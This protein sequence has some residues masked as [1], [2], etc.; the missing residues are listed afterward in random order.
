MK[1]PVVLS[2]GV[3]L[4]ASSSSAWA[5]IQTND[6]S[7]Q[8]PTDLVTSLLG[9]GVS[10]VSNVSYTGAVN[11]AGSFTGGSG[12]IGFE[13]GVV[14]S[15]GDIASVPGPNLADSITTAHGLFGDADLTALSGVFTYDASVLEF[16]FVPNADRIFFKYVFSS[17]EYD[18]FVNSP[19]NDA[20]AFLVNG[21]FGPVNCAVVGSPAVP[22]TIN[23]INNGPF[24]DGVAATNPAL[25]V[26]NNSP[27]TLDTEMDG[28]TVVLSCEAI[29]TPFATNHIK[30]AIADGSDLALDSNVFIQAGSFTTTPPDGSTC[31]LSQ[32]YWKT[33]PQEW[34]VQQLALGGV[35]YEQLALL[36]LLKKAVNGDASI[37]LSKQLIAAK[38]NLA[39]G[40]DGVPI[41][42]AVANADLLVGSSNLPMAVKNRTTLGRSMHAESS[43]LDSYNNGN[44]TPNCSTLEDGN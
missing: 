20:F 1:L 25:Y 21:G 13:S 22:V 6:L 31:P 23:T 33:H 14:L 43:L 37:A 19:F 35:T 24:N 40:A 34:P 39:N 5:A 30:L 4:V 2:L 42:T 36:A 44:L 18:E 28:L 26:N 3:A 15:S 17:D 16:D 7:A 27:P 32:G 29:V 41:T 10:S 11:S 9:A 8:T 12:I 38:L